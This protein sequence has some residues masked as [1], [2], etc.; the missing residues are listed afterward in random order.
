MK[1]RFL[2]YLLGICVLISACKKDEITYK[3]EVQ[4][5][6][7]T[8]LIDNTA[9]SGGI[10]TSEGRPTIQERG[11]EWCLS[12]NFDED[13]LRI[14]SDKPVLGEYT[15]VMSDLQQR[16]TY[17]VRAY[18]KNDFGVLY[19]NVL[20]FTTPAIPKVRTE[21]IKYVTGTTF[22]SG[23]EITD[24]GD[25]TILARG[26]CWG[27][28]SLPTIKG[29]HTSDSVGIGRFTSVVDHLTIGTKYYVRAYAKSAA[30]TGYGEV[31]SVT[32]HNYPKVT[33]GQISDIKY[34]SA[35]CGGRI[36]N[37]GGTDILS[38]GVC[39]AKSPA[40][41]TQKDS[42]MEEAFNNN[43]FSFNISGLQE[44]V[45]Y[46]VR[47]YAINSIGL[48]YGK[49]QT[50]ST[51][52][53]MPTVV[54]SDINNVSIRSAICSGK[55]TSDGGDA[56][57]ERGICYSSTEKLP[58]ISDE[59]N[60]SGKGIGTF[61]CELSHLNPNTKYYVRA[62]AK[63]GKGVAYGE[64]KTFTTL[65]IAL[66]TVVTTQ[67]SEV[68]SSS[69]ICS[70]NVTADGGDDVTER[71][72]C[73]SS[74][75]KQPTI[76]NGKKVEGSGMGAFS[77]KL[78]GLNKGVTYYVRAYA[79]NSKGVAYGSTI[80][81]STKSSQKVVTITNENCGW[82][83]TAGAQSSV[84]NG[85]EMSITEGVLGW[86]G[87][88]FYKNGTLTFSVSSGLIEKIEFTCIAQNDEKYGPGCFNAQTGYTYS[89]YQGT[90]IGNAKTVSFYTGVA[91]VRATKIVV[92]IQQ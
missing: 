71:G 64:Q 48:A 31:K 34:T 43:S 84:I 1:R 59:K 87:M 70:G 51:D 23:G 6:E 89:G 81:F 40:E 20:S 4:T 77:C 45:T 14:V 22:T 15:C 41:P 2:Y 49:V 12:K 80:S 65:D 25:S 10:I 36:D 35:K 29:L 63:N 7:V 28:N 9:T 76:S 30:G 83:T 66:P 8:S 18:A 24:D 60:S 58:S 91:Q 47:A 39:W 52:Y 53:H 88:R 57:T 3:T 27:T 19:G 44:G 38:C 55:V 33:T 85:V 69:A 92:T 86:D 13:V 17:Y 79:K 54:T 67:V 21:D 11:I 26:I 90:W 72:V 62:Y 56:V 74:S 37:N 32:T 46:N 5:K 50:F 75:V 42:H 61:S 68:T 73:Y 16:T 78:T 82:S